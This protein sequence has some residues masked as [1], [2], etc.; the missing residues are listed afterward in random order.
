MKIFVKFQIRAALVSCVVAC[1]GFGF[2]QSAA[3]QTTTNPQR[4]VAVTFDDLPGTGDLEK[5]RSVTTRLLRSVT[6]N[7]AP[8]VGFVNES[9]LYLNGKL[10]N[11]REALLR[12]WLDAGLELGNH[13]YSHRGANPTPL[14]DYE[15]DV[16]RGEPIT[17]RLL[18]ERGM[19]LRFFRHPM[20]QTGPTL[21]YTQGLRA[22]LVGRGYTIA[23][24]TLDNDDFIFAYVYADAKA[25][26][27]K[28]AMKRVA[29]AYV[30]YMEQ[31][32]AF[33][34]RLSVESFGYE[35]KQTLLLHANEINADYFDQL[36][37][38]I[39]RRGYTFITL[40]A[41]LKDKAY[42]LPEAQVESGV[43]WIPR[44]RLAKGLELR[45][46]PRE[47]EFVT[48]IYRNLTGYH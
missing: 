43:S 7:K 12:L 11:R 13:T 47:P 17:R 24:V 14:P 5:M 27:N 8:A 42:A 18:A 44:W 36:A 9:K 10:D 20:L 21:E 45:P 15:A 48:P 37:G 46:E 4:E 38:M 33:F 22:F 29:D 41:A 31:I 16:I 6:A 40:E 19:K 35:V 34:E 3:G 25:R 30:P 26:G 1:L 39:K 23:P 2:F 32:F 28:A